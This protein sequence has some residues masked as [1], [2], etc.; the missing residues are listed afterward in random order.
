MR[1]MKIKE[2][3]TF[4]LVNNYRTSASVLQKMDRYF[5]MWGKEGYLHYGQDRGQF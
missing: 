3:V 4:E 1:E 5:K 2:P